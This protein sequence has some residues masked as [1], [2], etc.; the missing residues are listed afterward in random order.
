MFQQ[1]SGTRSPLSLPPSPP[2]GVTGD[3]DSDVL[4]LSYDSLTTPSSVIDHHIPSG[5]RAT[6]KVSAGGARRRRVCF[7]WAPCRLTFARPRLLKHGRC[8]EYKRA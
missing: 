1:L 5:R 7:G 6:R 3:F 4:R 8:F 2:P